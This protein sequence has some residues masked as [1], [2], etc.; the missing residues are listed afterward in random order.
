M[1]LGLAVGAAAAVGAGPLTPLTPDAERRLAAGE[2]L[3]ELVPNPGGGPDEGVAV[4]VVDAPPERVFAALTDF[5]H[6]QEW[7]PFVSR[8]D[9]RPQPDG[10]V[11][12]AQSLRLPALVGNRSYKIRAVA[13][14]EAGKAGPVLRTRWTYVPGS[15]NVVD[16]RGA[17]TVT[18]FGAGRSLATCH[19]F[20]D[21]GSVPHWA[22]NRA[23]RQSLPWIFD[24]LRQQVRRERY[25][26]N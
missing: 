15:G 23:T 5:A 24:G 14:I 11:L 10:S 17:W 21:P 18:G 19:L 3:V 9:A 8:S 7:V 13:E 1:I 25:L 26:K 6:Y 22:M 2:V 12:S 4:G 16:T 20:T